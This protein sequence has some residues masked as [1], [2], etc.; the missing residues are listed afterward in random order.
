MHYQ[1]IDKKSNIRDSQQVD[2]RG[3]GGGGG[4]REIHNSELIMQHPLWLLP[5]CMTT[6]VK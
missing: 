5:A 1:N 3:G 6:R 4:T 2:S